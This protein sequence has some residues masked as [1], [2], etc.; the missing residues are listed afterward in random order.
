MV[1]FVS[2]FHH[3]W[4]S[5]TFFLHLFELHTLSPMVN[6]T[7][8]FW[9]HLRWY[10]CTKKSSNLKGKYKKSFAQDLRTKNPRV[11]YWWNWHLVYLFIKVW[12]ILFQ[13]F[14]IHFISYEIFELHKMKLYKMA[15]YEW[16][17]FDRYDHLMFRNSFEPFQAMPVDE[18]KLH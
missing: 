6:F 3:L 13:I 7:N 15:D 4:G 11:K 16:L 9:A 17:E 14:S 8:I 10:F 5:K 1:N 12:Q 18:N 2:K